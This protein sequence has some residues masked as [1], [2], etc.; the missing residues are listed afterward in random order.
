RGFIITGDRAYLAPYT[1]AEE[2][3]PALQAELHNLVADNP[4]Q[5]AALDNLYAA[6]ATRMK[7]LRNALII[8]QAGDLA[9]AVALVKKNAGYTAMQRVRDLYA[10]FDNAEASL[11]AQ[12]DQTAASQRTILAAFTIFSLLIAA[13]VAAMAAIAARRN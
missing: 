5:A 1:S 11:Q 2:R 4:P 10:V 13:A 6:I 9:G 7:A 8:A 3:L 12:H